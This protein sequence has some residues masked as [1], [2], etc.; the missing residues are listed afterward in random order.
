MSIQMI[1][2]IDLCR[3]WQWK[4]NHKSKRKQKITTPQLTNPVKRWAKT[5]KGTIHE[6]ANS[7]QKNTNSA[8]SHRNGARLAR[9]AHGCARGRC[10]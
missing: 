3:L 9:V 2:L 4:A 5:K 7:V 8:T 6:S 10:D 1:T